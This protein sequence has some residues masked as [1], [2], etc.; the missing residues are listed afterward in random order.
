MLDRYLV[1]P[2]EEYKSVCNSV[3]E[4]ILLEYY[5][6]NDYYMR[7]VNIDT[8]VLFRKEYKAYALRE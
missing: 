3:V 5:A 6:Q 7:R 1:K 2:E 4:Q 8:F